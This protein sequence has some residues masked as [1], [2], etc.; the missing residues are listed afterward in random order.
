MPRRI[1]DYPEMFHWWNWAC[2]L[3]SYMSLL[4]FFFFLYNVFGSLY[5]AACNKD[6]KDLDFMDYITR[7]MSRTNDINN[8]LRKAS[9]HDIHPAYQKSFME[10]RKKLFVAI[11]LKKLEKILEAEVEKE[12]ENDF[13]TLKDSQTNDFFT[14]GLFMNSAGKLVVGFPMGDEDT[15]E[16]D[17]SDSD[18]SDDTFDIKAFLKNLEKTGYD[19]SLES[20]KKEDKTNWN[21][22]K[23]ENKIKNELKQSN[24]NKT[25]NIIKKR[26]L[27]VK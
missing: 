2:T 15:D 19:T 11:R 13:N 12:L 17:S 4:S 18:T 7:F 22:K 16:E 21:I 5:I 23:S 9:I 20:K 10:Y 3:G 26:K 1:A 27:G 6:K 25:Q 14:H 24:E 8:V